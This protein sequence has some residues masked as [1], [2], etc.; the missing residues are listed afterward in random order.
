[1]KRL[2]NDGKRAIACLLAW[3]LLHAM[4][5]L[6][7]EHGDDLL[8]ASGTHD[9]I[10]QLYESPKYTLV[11]TEDELNQIDE[12]DAIMHPKEG[13]NVLSGTS[14]AVALKKQPIPQSVF[15]MSASRKLLGQVAGVPGGYI[16]IRLS[17]VGTGE[18]YVSFTPEN[19]GGGCKNNCA[20]T[21]LAGSQHVQLYRTKYRVNYNIPNCPSPGAKAWIAPGHQAMHGPKNQDSDIDMVQSS[22][23]LYWGLGS[24]NTYVNNVNW[25]TQA[26][27]SCSNRNNNGHHCTNGGFM[28]RDDIYN[29]KT[30]ATS[31]SAFNTACCTNNGQCGTLNGKY[32]W[33]ITEAT[34]HSTFGQSCP[35][36]Y[37]K[38]GNHYNSIWVISADS[39]PGSFQSQCCTK[40]YCQEVNSAGGSCAPGHEYDGN[41][42]YYTPTTA[43][44][45]GYRSMCCKLKLQ[46]VAA[47]QNNLRCTSAT[48]GGT[49]PA[50]HTG[51]GSTA[52][53]T[54]TAQGQTSG[55]TEFNT[56]CC[57]QPTCGNI[58]GK[59]VR[60][61]TSG[62][63]QQLCNAEW[64]TIDPLKNAAIVSTLADA[65]A[66]TGY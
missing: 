49:V 54:A 8:S 10:T 23:K 46:C 59:T 52:V 2:S 7:S 50:H 3:A 57:V 11:T 53:S 9:Q 41:R 63:Q 45:A 31:G 55:Q 16:Y 22:Y 42:A 6:A 47:Y 33:G 19:E 65:T 44:E 30:V 5:A 66:T 26:V 43:D 24:G 21:T 12:H 64:Q 38:F 18:S 25:N 1:M 51:L 29:V 37:L 62:T 13:K 14:T 58:G 4:C 28:S 27:P 17:C 61:G 20:Q 34:R 40:K 56:N 48:V 36:P 35:G 60:I 15:P 39:T 32:I